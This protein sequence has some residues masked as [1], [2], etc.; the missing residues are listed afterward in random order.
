M[1]EYLTSEQL[2]LKHFDHLWPLAYPRR[3]KKAYADHRKTVEHGTWNNL[4]GLLG[5]DTSTQE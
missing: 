3:S 1:P 4:G 5:H 2:L